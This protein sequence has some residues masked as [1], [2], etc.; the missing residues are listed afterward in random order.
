MIFSIY[1]K[2]NNGLPK[3]SHLTSQNLWMTYQC[4]SLLTLSPVTF[5]LF[6]SI[7]RILYFDAGHWM[8]QQKTTQLTMF[9][10][11]ETHF[12]KDAREDRVAVI[13][14]QWSNDTAGLG[15]FEGIVKTP[16]SS[17]RG[18]MLAGFVWVHWA[19]SIPFRKRLASNSRS[20]PALGPAQCEKKIS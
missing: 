7:S 18:L 16:H 19:L 2:N 9:S 8:N 14:C 6:L 3:V 13:L 17:I 12:P 15:L 5:L 4:S 10:A 1:S 11:R 20:L